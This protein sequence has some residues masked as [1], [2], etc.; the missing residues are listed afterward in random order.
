MLRAETVT[1]SGSDYLEIWGLKLLEPSGSVQTCTG[2]TLPFS[3][4]LEAEST[5]DHIVAGETK[6]MKD[7]DDPIGNQ[8]RD[9]PACIAV[10]QP[11][12]LIA[13]YVL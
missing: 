2:I 1:P 8:A 7:L 4:L 11:N 5:Q 12:D 6:S 10:P 3:F 13:F 9:L